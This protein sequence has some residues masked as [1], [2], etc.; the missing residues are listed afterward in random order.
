MKILDPT[1]KDALS[2]KSLTLAWCWLITRL[3]GMQLGFTSL[4]VPITI[5]GITYYGITGFDPGAAQQSQGVDKLD[6]QT[7]KGILD[8]SGISKAE[9]DSGIFE[10]ARVRRFLST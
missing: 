2:Q 4:D 1:F 5:G 6:S 9:L 10:G 8:V 7:L 3:D